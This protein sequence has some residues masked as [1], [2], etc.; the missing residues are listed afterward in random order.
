MP[1]LVAGQDGHPLCVAC[2]LCA[3]ACPTD[4]LLVVPGDD[5]L[6]VHARR[7]ERFELDMANCLVCGLCEEA[8]PEEAIV[9]SP[10]DRRALPVRESAVFVLDEL[11][12]PSERVQGWRLHRDRYRSADHAAI[13]AEKDV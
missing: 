10:L 5:P 9:M 8:C 12:V 11:L 13:G 7:P 2:G 6:N 1:L 4:C 3:Y